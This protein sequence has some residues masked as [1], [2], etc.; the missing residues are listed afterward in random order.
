MQTLQAP[1]WTRHRGFSR[2]VRDF[3]F[4]LLK[5]HRDLVGGLVLDPELPSA[6]DL[7]D[8][9]GYDL[10]HEFNRTTAYDPHADGDVVI[11]H[12]ISPTFPAGPMQTVLPSSFLRGNSQIVVTLHDIIPLLFPDLY[13]TYPTVDIFHKSRFRIAREADHV[14]TVS[15]TTKDDGVKHLGLDPG[16]TTVSW[17][18][19]SPEFHPPVE[20]RDVVRQRLSESVPQIT[21]PFIF[22]LLYT[23]EFGKRKNMEGAIAGFARMSPEVRAAYQFVFAGHGWQSDYDQ[24][25]AYAAALGVGDRLAFTGLVSDELLR[26][27]YQACDLFIF[28][29]FYEG[30][31]LPVVEAMRSAAPTVVSERS[32][33][34]EIMEL[35][36]GKF[37][38]EDFDEIGAVMQRALTD[39]GYKQHLVD[40]GLQRADFF[41]WG[42]VAD[43]AADCYH[44]VAE[45]KANRRSWSTPK[46]RT[47]VISLPPGGTEASTYVRRIAETVAQRHPVDIELALAEDTGTAGSHA[48]QLA[49]V[50]ERQAR[51]LAKHA[52]YDKIIHCMAN[53]AGYEAAYH[54]IREFRGAVW[55]FDVR[56]S[57]FYRSYFQTRG[58]DLKKI[59]PSSHT[60]RGD[61]PSSTIL[62]SSG[63]PQLS[64]STVSTWPP[65]L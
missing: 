43:I 15:Q 61:T 64:M 40:Y 10:L 28:P 17:G 51:W 16:R 32:S 1:L 7:A 9:A 44:E 65:R 38:P 45:R 52:H 12:V 14:L 59:P 39:Q 23:D 20:P 21:G 13:M 31:G 63:T 11:Y 8:Y 53:D 33:T 6:K 41:S 62:F 4:A 36:D 24:L 46:V 30:L 50:S 57:S 27:L 37:D 26:T 55:L 3:T 5:N 18:G 54:L 19:V 42:R 29:S 47:V 48:G 58:Y 60:G 22:T 34:G 35:A 2:T 25:T 49:F 56:L